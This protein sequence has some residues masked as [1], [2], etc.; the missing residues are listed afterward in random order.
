MAP[1]VASWRDKMKTL[2]QED[3]NDLRGSHDITHSDDSEVT[4]CLPGSRIGHC[5]DSLGKEQRSARR[6]VSPLSSASGLLYRAYD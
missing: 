6:N 2:L 1:A 3:L 4:V 5:S